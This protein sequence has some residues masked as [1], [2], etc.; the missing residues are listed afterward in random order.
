MLQVNG[1]IGDIPESTIGDGNIAVLSLN[2]VVIAPEEI[3]SIDGDMTVL[4][5]ES[6]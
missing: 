3:D 1:M 2:E 4:E 6:W 5:F